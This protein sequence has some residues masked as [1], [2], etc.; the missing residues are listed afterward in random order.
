MC[1][2]TFQVKSA[3]FVDENE[4]QWTNV[5]QPGNLKYKRDKHLVND[6][7]LIYAALTLNTESS[8]W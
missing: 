7:L 1:L 2:L 4:N 6:L 5:S 3:T 8:N